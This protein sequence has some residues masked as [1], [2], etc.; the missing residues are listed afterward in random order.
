M[1][2]PCT[3]T[4]LHRLSCP[5]IL[6]VSDASLVRP[7][8]NAGFHIEV[9]G[10]TVNVTPTMEVSHPALLCDVKTSRQSVM[11]TVEVDLGHS[12]GRHGNVTQVTVFSVPQP[13][14]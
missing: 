9:A 10:V 12:D 4:P 7:Q 13:Q 3:P 8:L 11:A 1:T 5:L 2:G 6:Q 14:L